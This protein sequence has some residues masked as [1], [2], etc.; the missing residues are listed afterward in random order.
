MISIMPPVLIYFFGALLLPAIKNRRLSQ[1]FALLIPV[2]AFFNLL[3]MPHG[4]YWAFD[5]INYQLVLGRV[6]E[7]EVDVGTA[8][9]AHLLGLVVGGGQG[10][11][12]PAPELGEGAFENGRE[13]L[14]AILEVVIDRGRRVADPLGDGTHGHGLGPIGHEDAFGRLDD[15]RAQRLAAS[16]TTGSRCGLDLFVG[17][18]W[19]HG[20]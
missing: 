17:G 14:V 18:R 1:G 11:G 8:H 2:L 6:L 16:L 7:R 12:E 15:A 10:S 19:R 20:R 13:E 9:P 3:Q 5:F 4:T